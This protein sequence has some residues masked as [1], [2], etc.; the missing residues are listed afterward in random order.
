LVT[1][2]TP[3]VKSL[4]FPSTLPE[5]F[6]TPPTTEA[7]KSAPGRETRPPEPDG[8]DGIPDADADGMDDWR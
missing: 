4:T 1:L 5:K 6:C 2:V 8:M 7:A 3:L